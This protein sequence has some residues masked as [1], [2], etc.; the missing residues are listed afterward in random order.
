MRDEIA[1]ALQAIRDDMLVSLRRP[2][3][4]RRLVRAASSPDFRGKISVGS[5]NVELADWLNTDVTWWSK[6]YLDLT[7]PWPALMRGR[8]SH[9][10]ADNVIE[11]FPLPLA[12]TVLRNA[13]DALGEGGRIR[14]ATPDIEATARAYL[15]DATLTSEHLARHRRKGFLAEHPV[16][17]LRVTYAYHGHHAGYCFDWQS[18]R[19]EMQL[20]GFRDIIRCAAGES[21]DEALRGL[22]TRNEPTEIATELIVE[23]QRVGDQLIPE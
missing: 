13:F 21:E 4:S 17:M 14:L 22:E 9:I 15:D 3:T 18:L 6:L 8:V 5:G 19:D 20:A 7:Q 2:I 11:H 12:R 1:C 10:Y 23:G 16:D